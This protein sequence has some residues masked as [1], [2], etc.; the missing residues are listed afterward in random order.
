VTRIGTAPV[1]DEVYAAAAAQFAEDELVKLTLAILATHAWN[2]LNVAFHRPAG[3][4]TPGMFK[5][6]KFA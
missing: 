4:Y 5:H 3:D 1:A 6:V 2:R